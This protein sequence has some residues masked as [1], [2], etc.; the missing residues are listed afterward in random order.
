M[1]LLVF[2]FQS[3]RLFGTRDIFSRNLTVDVKEVRLGCI[4]VF[5]RLN[6]R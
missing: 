6:T 4:K 3:I 5:T 1:L 2:I